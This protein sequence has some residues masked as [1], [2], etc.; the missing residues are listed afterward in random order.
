MV[1]FLFLCE[2]IVPWSRFV[3]KVHPVAIRRALFCVNYG[4]CKLVA[5]DTTGEQIVLAYSMIGSLSPAFL[6]Y[7]L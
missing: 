7:M 6:R 1:R 2:D 4:F 5:A 3:S